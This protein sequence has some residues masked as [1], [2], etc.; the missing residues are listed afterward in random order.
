M[1]SL[2]Q[3][4]M[5]TFNRSTALAVVAVAFGL[6]AIAGDLLAATGGCTR[7]RANNMAQVF[8]SQTV[9]ADSTIPSSI[10]LENEAVFGILV[11]Q[12]PDGSVPPVCPGD[13]DGNKLVNFADVT[14]VLGNWATDC[15]AGN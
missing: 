9:R 10:V 15:N 3:R 12:L 1:T 6:G 4:T 5:P 13:A 2:R 8:N 11:V 7:S 14:S